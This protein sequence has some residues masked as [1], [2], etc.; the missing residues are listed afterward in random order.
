MNII[1]TSILLFCGIFPASLPL[2]EKGWRGLIPLHSTRTD[3]ERVLGPSSG[4][5]RCIYRTEEEVVSVIYS[6]TNCKGNVPGWNVPAETVLE[7]TV[8]P[9]K[10]Q[11][12]FSELRL[13]KR[14]FVRTQDHVATTAYYTN[15]AMGIR[16]QVSRGEVV[17]SVTY[18]PQLK[19][20]RLRCAGFPPYDGGIAKYRPFDIFKNLPLNLEEARLADFAIQLQN[21]PDWKGYIVVYAGKVTR[22]HEAKTRAR[23]ARNYLIQK[24]NLAPKRIVALDGGYRDEFEI[25]LY[26]ID[27]AQPAPTPAPT[28]PP[29]EV[30][31]NNA[32]K[33][34]K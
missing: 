10:R 15:L 16:Y 9:L 27:R 25:E 34:H 12:K 7:F 20:R 17:D 26:L 23:Q 3:V 13:D 33:K 8:M 5:C 1:L 11:D 6:R 30:I 32:A 28:L 14:R 24:L 31:F 2:E 22:L 18:I 29:S 4:D 21:N 19:D